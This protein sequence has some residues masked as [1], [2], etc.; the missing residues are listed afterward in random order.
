VWF[1]LAAL[2]L[3]P[4]LLD[5][6]AGDRARVASTPRATLML[7]LAAG[8]LT[9]ALV[10][11]TRPSSWYG[12]LWPD[13]ALAAVSSATSNPATKVFASDREADWL[14]WR[15]PQ[16]RGRMAYDVRFELDT[17][18]QVRRLQRYFGRTGPN[19]QAAARGYDVIVLDRRDNESVRRSLMRQ[20]RLR[21]RYLDQN[22]AVLVRAGS[23]GASG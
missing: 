23:P 3:L 7:A 6:E 5:L 18:A 2:V 13:R 1:G 10:F 8:V 19:W 22:L 16:L 15:L 11:A 14:L 17:S 12:H 9:T 21:Q 20:G 4:V